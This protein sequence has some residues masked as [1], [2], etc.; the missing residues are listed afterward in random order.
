MVVQQ[1]RLYD[2]YMPSFR[3]HDKGNLAIIARGAAVAD[4]KRHRLSGFLASV[5][6]LVV[7]L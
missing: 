5:A 1:A 7:H 4:I 6:W 3:Y 2:R